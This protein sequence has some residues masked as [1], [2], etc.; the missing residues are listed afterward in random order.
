MTL[1]SCINILRGPMDSQR[2]EMHVK[3]C[4]DNHLN[5]S[6]MRFLCSNMTGLSGKLLGGLI[7][8]LG[9]PSLPCPSSTTLPHTCRPFLHTVH[10]VPFV[11]IDFTVNLSSFYKSFKQTKIPKCINFSLIDIHQLFPKFKKL[12]LTIGGTKIF[13]V[14]SLP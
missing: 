4:F 5:S 12:N 6:V 3:S 8:L 9:L 1:I 10:T 13:R 2:K 11:L 14:Q 7:C